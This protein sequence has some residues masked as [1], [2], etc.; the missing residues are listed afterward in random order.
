MKRC[1]QWSEGGPTPFV[2]VVSMPQFEILSITLNIKFRQQLG[3]NSRP[4][5]TVL[6]MFVALIR[7]ATMFEQLD[8]HYSVVSGL[9]KRPPPLLFCFENESVCQNKGWMPAEIIKK[10]WSVGKTQSF[11]H[12]GLNFNSEVSSSFV[13]SGVWAPCLCRNLRKSKEHFE[14]ESVCQNKEWMPAEI[15]KKCWSVDKTQS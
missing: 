7:S 4:V 11:K 9:A 12:N 15:I 1:V 8:W 2:S 14:N 5:K 6:L 13:L 10:C 3:S